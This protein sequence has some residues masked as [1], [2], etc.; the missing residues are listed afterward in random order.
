M[1]DNSMSGRWRC[2]VA[3]ISNYGWKSFKSDGHSWWVSPPSP[4]LLEVCPLSDHV[5]PSHGSL[6]WPKHFSHQF[7]FLP[8]FAFP[9]NH[10]NEALEDS[11]NGI[12]LFLLGILLE[13]LCMSLRISASLFGVP[14]PACPGHPP[15]GRR[16]L[17]KDAMGVTTWEGL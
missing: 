3:G 17:D 4:Y 12:I 1:L 8:W 9:K 5:L 10:G 6:T 14:P 16:A 15:S 7:W 13:R 2:H 11:S